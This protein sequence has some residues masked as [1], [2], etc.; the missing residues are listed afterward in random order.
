MVPAGGIPAPVAGAHY[1]DTGILRK[2]FTAVL[3]IQPITVW[4]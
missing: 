2:N 4:N 1:C 3:L